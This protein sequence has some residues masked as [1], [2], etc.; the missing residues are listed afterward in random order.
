MKNNLLAETSHKSKRSNKN[1]PIYRNTQRKTK[2]DHKETA[3]IESALI[4]LNANF[5]ICMKEAVL[6]SL[7][8]NFLWMKIT[9][10]N[11][12]M[13]CLIFVCLFPVLCCQLLG[14]WINFFEYFVERYVKKLILLNILF[15]KD[16]FIVKFIFKKNE[17]LCFFFEDKY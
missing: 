15:K 3:P 10:S 6:M 5:K 12:K 9:R 16:R 17:T 11:S 1:F 13:R 8:L 7:L 2:N 14:L 4:I